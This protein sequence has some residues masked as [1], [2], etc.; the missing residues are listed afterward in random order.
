[1]IVC[2]SCLLQKKSPVIGVQT[3]FVQMVIMNDLI[4]IMALLQKQLRSYTIS[5]D[6]S[7]PS[8]SGIFE[9]GNFLLKLDSLQSGE[10]APREDNPLYGKTIFSV[11]DTI[12]YLFSFN[13]YYY[14][15][16][17]K[18]NSLKAIGKFCQGYIKLTKLLIACKCHA[19]R[20]V[21]VSS[22]QH[23][24]YRAEVVEGVTVWQILLQFS[25]RLEIKYLYEAIRPNSCYFSF[26]YIFNVQN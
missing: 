17:Q 12:I 18:N 13:F 23:S 4:A 6:C 15:T 26:I 9:L 11:C 2:L 10:F 19:C 24:N 25:N 5:R 3:L 1:M 7:F 21:Q 20:K 16:A 14:F 8:G 22:C